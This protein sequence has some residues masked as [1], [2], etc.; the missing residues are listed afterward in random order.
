MECK[1]LTSG[2]KFTSDFHICKGIYVSYSSD[3]YLYIFKFWLTTLNRL[4]KWPLI[5]TF[6]SVTYNRIW[7]YN[8]VFISLNS[9]IINLSVSVWSDCRLPQWSLRARL[10]GSI[11]QLSNGRKGRWGGMW[12]STVWILME[13]LAQSTLLTW[14]TFCFIQARLRQLSKKQAI[15]K[16]SDTTSQL[17]FHGK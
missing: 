11:T 12:W 13:P 4:I 1:H 6:F 5:H 3:I 9:W 7:A 8:V 14:S 10:S 2:Q 15:G 16:K 17:D